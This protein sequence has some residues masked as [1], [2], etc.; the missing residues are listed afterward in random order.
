ML[1]KLQK[2]QW[3]W[4]QRRPPRDRRFIGLDGKI[5]IGGG[6]REKPWWTVFGNCQV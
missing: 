5:G 1:L 3:L 4:N 6:M 2:F